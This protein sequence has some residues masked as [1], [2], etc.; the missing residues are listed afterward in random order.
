MWINN[1][2]RLPKERGQSRQPKLDLSGKRKPKW[3]PYQAYSHLYWETRLKAEIDPEYPVYVAN[4]P[5]GEGTQ[6]LL[7]FRNRRLRE[8]LA[9][10][11]A[12]V[13]AEVEA[14]RGKPVSIKD[15]EDL[16]EMLKMGL[17]EE[18]CRENNRKM[19]VQSL[20]RCCCAD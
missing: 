4:V 10:E 12:A 16:N 5:L 14:C 20:T 1:H 19:Y 15:E 18:E 13:K 2:T 11:T 3:Q 8:L 6:S 9:N 17:S 7:V